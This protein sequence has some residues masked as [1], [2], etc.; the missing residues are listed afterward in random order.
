MST[1]VI[2][3]FLLASVALNFASLG[4][5]AWQFGLGSDRRSDAP[6][7]EAAVAEALLAADQ[8]HD[9]EVSILTTSRDASEGQLAS[10]LQR[11]HASMNRVAMLESA[12]GTRNASRRH[13][14]LGADPS[15]RRDALE[16]DPDLASTLASL[17]AEATMLER[18][19]SRAQ[20][21]FDQATQRLRDAERRLKE[22]ENTTWRHSKKSGARSEYD[23]LHKLVDDWR[24]IYDQATKERNAIEIQLN[25]VVR[26][27]NYIE[28]H[29]RMPTPSHPY[30]PPSEVTPTTPRVGIPGSR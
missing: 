19:L 23:A 4:V 17:R 25:E 15:G 18:S 20:A 27:R 22:F 21:A 11:L 7:I 6:R 29:N 9:A 1:R 2:V 28:R 5:I 16:V 3:G 8:R 30:E 13:A 12:A 14:G 10:A 24:R 26:Q